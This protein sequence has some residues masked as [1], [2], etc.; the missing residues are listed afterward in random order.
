MRIESD[1]LL[2]IV[3]R[4][5]KTIIVQHTRDTTL[6]IPIKGKFPLGYR[7]IVREEV[8][9]RFRHTGYQPINSE[10]IKI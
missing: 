2:G 7:P 9:S 1:A 3:E 5:K 6:T 4:Q 10:L 8:L